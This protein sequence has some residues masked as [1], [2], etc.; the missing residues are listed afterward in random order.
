MKTYYG[1]LT[2]TGV[3]RSIRKEL[4]QMDRVFYGC[5]F[6]HP[7]VEFFIAQISKLLANY[8]CNT[9]LGIHLQTSMELMVIECG[10]SCQ[11]LAQ[12]YQIF[13]KWVT[14]CCLKSVWEKVDLFNLTVTIKSLPLRPPQE[15]DE[16]T[17]ANEKRS[18]PLF[19]GRCFSNGSGHGCGTTSDGRG[20]IT[21]LQSRFDRGHVS[22]SR[23]GHI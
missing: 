12:P 15:N 13:S 18:S 22:P 1:L 14:H 21:G 4:Q 2:I 20:T 3:R 10:V 23:T 19:F 7:G 16:W 8:G 11:I 9:G 17:S 5:G 6:P